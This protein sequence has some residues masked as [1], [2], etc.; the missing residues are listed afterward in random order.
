MGPKTYT[1][2]WPPSAS[3]GIL[4]LRFDALLIRNSPHSNINDLDVFYSTTS[5]KIQ[6]SKSFLK[7]T[8]QEGGAF[9]ASCCDHT[10]YPRWLFLATSAVAFSLGRRSTGPLNPSLVW[11]WGSVSPSL[12]QRIS[13][14]G[15]KKKLN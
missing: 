13:L 6:L 11:Q 4:M 12:A 5:P 15:G 3:F 8:G 10:T 14:S 7:K 9:P 2:E 1:C